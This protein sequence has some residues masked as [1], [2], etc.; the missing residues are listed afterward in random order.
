[1]RPLGPVCRGLKVMAVLDWLAYGLYSCGVNNELCLY[2][3]LHVVNA[4]Q[5]V[6]IVHLYSSKTML[7]T[8]H[9]IWDTVFM[10]L[11]S[12]RF[13]HT[14]GALL[15]WKHCYYAGMSPWRHCCYGYTHTTSPQLCLHILFLLQN[16]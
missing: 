5:N 13:I 3:V 2:L 9:F 7:W 16:N 4:V 12:G 15:L 1:M 6:S 8:L 11:Y 10:I 14:V